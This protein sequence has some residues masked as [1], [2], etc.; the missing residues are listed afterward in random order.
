M[1]LDE[2][3]LFIFLV[4]IDNV[5]G[6]V[7]FRQLLYHLFHNETFTHSALA[8]KS[9]DESLAE[10]SFYFFRIVWSIDNFHTS[11]CLIKANANIYTFVE[12]SL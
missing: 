6:Y 8:G 2:R 3:K 1:R 12:Y 11:L 4:N 9:D 7:M 5:Y 10:K